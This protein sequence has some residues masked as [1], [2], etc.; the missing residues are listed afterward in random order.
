MNVEGGQDLQQIEL[1]VVSTLS[2]H[3]PTAYDYLYG[4]LVRAYTHT[5][6]DGTV[7]VNGMSD[8]HHTG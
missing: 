3:V 6:Q 5:R 2:M 1:C 4:H 8:G 7:D